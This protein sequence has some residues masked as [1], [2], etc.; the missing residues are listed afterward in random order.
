VT[1]PDAGAAAAVAD[2][3]QP[4]S[5]RA[6]FRGMRAAVVVLTRLPVGGFPYAEAEWRWSCAHM[7]LVGALVGAIAAL[8]G[9]AVARA[10]HLVAAV[11]VVTA[12]M[13]VTGAMHE[14][15]L[16]DTADALGGG[17]TR[18]RVL[19]ILKD[20][21][22][23]VFGACALVAAI[24][25][26]VAAMARLTPHA[27]AAIVLVGATSRL[28]PV[29]LIAALPYVTEASVAKSRS[30]ATAGAAQLVVA[31]AWVCAV[32]A[33]VRALGGVS[34]VELAV[35]LASGT[36]TT[37]VC[38]ACFRARVGGITGDFLGAA[39]QACECAM[40]LAIAVARG[41]GG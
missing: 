35:A 33:G 14:D 38:G 13:L 2:S 36:L 30:V 34:T 32:G 26:R 20:S 24:L 11:G 10:G 1:G 7:P 40:L 4:A 21:R 16:A 37:V 12:S 19:E 18:A 6:F 41:G 39:Q 31:F 17:D 15:G 8:A 25:L 23:G 3:R 22:I 28:A 9:V 27:V 5:P 29:A